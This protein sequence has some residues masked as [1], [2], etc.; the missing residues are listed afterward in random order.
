MITRLYKEW[1]DKLVLKPFKVNTLDK[2]KQMSYATTLQ[3]GYGVIK[4]PEGKT[5]KFKIIEE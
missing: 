2:V 5:I 4:T 3:E 1:F